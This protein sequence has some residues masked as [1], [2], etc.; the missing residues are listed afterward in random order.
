MAGA[1]SA[2]SQP[3]SESLSAR[4]ASM[5]ADV[6]MP[7]SP[8]STVWVSVNLSRTILTASMKAVGSA[9]LP[10]N[11]LIATGRPSGSV[12]SPYSIWGRFFFPSRE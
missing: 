6:I 7:R 2:V 10:G 4:S 9:V 12:S 8:T 3:R 1:R 11:T 5:R